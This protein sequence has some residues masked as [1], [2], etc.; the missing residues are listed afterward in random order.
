MGRLR[1]SQVG[2]CAG[3]VA[4][5]AGGLGFPCG[6]GAVTGVKNVGWPSSRRLA[7]WSRKLA[8]LGSV[9]GWLEPVAKVIGVAPMLRQSHRWDTDAVASAVAS[10]RGWGKRCGNRAR[11]ALRGLWQ[12]LRAW[13]RGLGP[14]GWVN[15]ALR[16]GRRPNDG[17]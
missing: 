10:A 4:G 2:D 3:G 17:G 6:L 14:R 11:A 16:W 9:S 7:P 13:D 8:W 1:W 15:E 12:A 5:L